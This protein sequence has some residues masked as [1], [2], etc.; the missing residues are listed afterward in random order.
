M[1][2]VSINIYK[3]A[4]YN[5]LNILFIYRKFHSKFDGSGFYNRF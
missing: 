4:E 1:Y 2:T 5:A 3:I